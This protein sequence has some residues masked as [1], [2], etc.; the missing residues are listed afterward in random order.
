[1]LELT[2][3]KRL[4]IR[5]DEAFTDIHLEGLSESPPAAASAPDGTPGENPLETTANPPT[6]TT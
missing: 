4:R 6:V 2:R 5:Q 1:M 3:I